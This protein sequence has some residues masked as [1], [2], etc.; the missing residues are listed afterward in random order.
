MGGAGAVTDSGGISMGCRC[1]WDKDTDSLASE[2]F[3]NVRVVSLCVQ[4][5]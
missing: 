4:P 5:R 1:F 3:S 2:S